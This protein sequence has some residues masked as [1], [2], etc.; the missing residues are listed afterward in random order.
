[1]NK[2]YRSSIIDS[3]SMMLDGY[4]NMEFFLSR[5]KNVDITQTF[6]S[7]KFTRVIFDNVILESPKMRNCTFCGC[8]FT[9]S[10]W[11]Q[12]ELPKH[13]GLEWNEPDK[14]TVDY[15]D[16]FTE[17]RPLDGFVM[18]E[19][20]GGVVWFS[21]YDDF[22]RY[23]VLVTE[24]KREQKRSWLSQVWKDIKM[25][26]ELRN[27]MDCTVLYHGGFGAGVVGSYAHKI[28]KNIWS[29]WIDTP[30]VKPF[31][32]DKSI[33]P[34]LVMKQHLYAGWDGISNTEMAKWSESLYDRSNVLTV[35]L[36]HDFNSNPM[37]YRSNYEPCVILLPFLDE[38][39]RDWEVYVKGSVCH[40]SKGFSLIIRKE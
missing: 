7:V 36:K 22:T 13:P 25:E 1:M 16:E 33:T 40:G 5:F 12:D 10:Y 9:G 24:K 18:C 20:N 19:E 21:D 35:A 28:D 26:W 29:V 8:K 2:I 34:F 11:I 38:D 14:W 32:K 6:S 37:K 3:E 4:M 39:D 17:H 31:D 30:E 15:W 27:T 23:C